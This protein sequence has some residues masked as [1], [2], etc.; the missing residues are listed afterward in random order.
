MKACGV[1]QGIRS[2]MDFGAQATL[3]FADTLIVFRGFF[4][5]PA[6][7]WCAR[8]IV[9]SIMAYSLSAASAKTSKILTHTPVLAH[10]LCRV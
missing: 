10:R 3:A 5:A 1:A 6:L 9:E 2:C 7:C 4:L 8:T